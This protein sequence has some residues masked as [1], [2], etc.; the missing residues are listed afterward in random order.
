MNRYS[1]LS[2]DARDV[3]AEV[4]NIGTG[5]A[6]AALASMIGRKCRSF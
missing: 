2:D 5:N 1:E 6:V 4:G 3:L